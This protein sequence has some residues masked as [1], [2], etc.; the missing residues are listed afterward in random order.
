MLCIVSEET[1]RV[2][3]ERRMRILRDLGSA[4]AETR[5]EEDVYTTL[6]SATGDRPAQDPVQPCLPH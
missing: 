4:L 2:V 1:S 5:T 6:E 3:N